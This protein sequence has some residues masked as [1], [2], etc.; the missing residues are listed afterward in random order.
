MW[1]EIGVQLD[2]FAYAPQVV[3]GPLLEETILSP[4]SGLGT[5]RQK[6]VCRRWMGLS[7]DTQFYLTVLYIYPYGGDT[8]FNFIGRFFVFV[9][10]FFLGPHLRH[11][12]V[13]R[14]GVE[15]ELQLL[16]YTTATAMPD[17]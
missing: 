9:F 10:V 4:F 15:L 5:L 8:P 6:S 11:M 3:P 13:T 12:D 2:L 17:P 1:C 16:P 14:L 7:L